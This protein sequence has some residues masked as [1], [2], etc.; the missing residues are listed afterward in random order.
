MHKKRTHTCNDL[1]KTHVGQQVTLSGWVNSCR[2]LGGLV[3]IDLRDR[4]G[5]TQ[6][7]VNPPDLPDQMDTIR[8]IREEWVLTATGC[9]NARP[10]NMVNA[11]MP[12]G[13]IEVEVTGLCIDNRSRPMPFHLDD[14][15]VSEDLR[16][17]YR[18]LDMRR[19]GLAENLRLRHR[20]T[21]LVRDYFDTEGFCEVE[22]PVLSKSTP[23]GARDYLIPSR[24]HPGKFF[25][26]PQAPQ[27]YK[28][29]LMVGGV[30]KYFQIARCFRDE[31]LRAD[32]Q[33]EFT[34]IDVEMSFVET[35]DIIACIE[36]MLVHV[37]A[38]IGKPVPETPFPRL[39]YQDAMERYGSDKPDTRFGMEL[40]DLGEALKA[41]EFRVFRGVLESGGVIKAINAKG[42]ADGA[43]KRQLDTWT[44]CVKQLGAKGLAWLKVEPNGDLKGQIA[45]FLSSAETDSLK[46]CLQTEPGD[47]V[48][49]VAD[50][51]DVVNAAL[52]RLRLEVARHAD[53][54]PEGIDAFLWVV[55]FPLLEYDA[56][57]ERY[58]AMHHPFTSPKQEDVARLETEPAAVRAKAYDVVMNGVELGGGSIRI[59]QPDL[60]S[61]M[62]AALGIDAEE[63]SLRFGHLL[64]ALSFGAPPH[65]GIALGMDRFVMLLAGV[66]S[67]RD[68]I[69]FPKT[70]RA[71][72]LMTESPSEVDDHQLPELGIQ[73]LPQE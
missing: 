33:P 28:Q 49:I 37:M 38:G 67:I 31:D 47:L 21:K 4:E 3:F 52:G 42:V 41:T 13:E 44:D 53:M 24:V 10:A 14:P 1:N 54:I 30:E 59:H 55:D 36:G 12:T 63:A 25:A 71:A 60:Q 72:C 16:L 57:A 32:R 35:D 9:V 46:S 18:Y 40:T 6:L 58:T 26:L 22:T 69:A 20:I 27:Q 73:L 66:P 7:V 15:T 65:G 48:L 43:N 62:F 34:Q 11:E 64:E 8:E 17:K 61:R 56:E 23:E 70:T 29:L 51:R 2:D 50:T 39:T 5:V 68:V 19:S 45:K